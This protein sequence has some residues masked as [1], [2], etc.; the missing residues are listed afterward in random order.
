M[1]EKQS[2]TLLKL[3]LSDEISDVLE[4]EREAEDLEE[5]RE[6]AAL[7]A[8]AISAKE[9]RKRDFFWGGGGLGENKVC[10]W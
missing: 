8:V 7:T 10:V 2:I 5:G 4:E 9:E 6:T 1:I 3:T